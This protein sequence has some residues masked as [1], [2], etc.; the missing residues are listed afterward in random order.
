M[1]VIKGALIV[2]LFLALIPVSNAGSAS[3][4]VGLEIITGSTVD[5]KD[6]GQK[7]VAAPADRDVAE[8]EFEIEKQGKG[9]SVVTGDAINDTDVKYCILVLL[10]VL[11]LIILIMILS[12]IM[13]RK[14]NKN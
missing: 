5:E 2:F 4:S 12:H 7:V 14:R 6:N 11:A 8:E 3:G 10:P 13:Y 9:L 1:G